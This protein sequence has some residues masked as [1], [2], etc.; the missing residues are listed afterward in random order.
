M[1]KRYQN[2]VT[3]KRLRDEDAPGDLASGRLSNFGCCSTIRWVIFQLGSKPIHLKTKYTNIYRYQV[4]EAMAK[5]IPQLEALIDLEQSESFDFWTR[6][7]INAP[8]DIMAAPDQVNQLL[9][10]LSK[11]QIEYS[12]KINNVQEYIEM[13]S[14][15]FV[16]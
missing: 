9:N 4:Y 16:I 1:T 14:S 3:N 13:R 6:V 11:Y 8:T 10:Y 5:D 7:R 2:A 15:S 12:I